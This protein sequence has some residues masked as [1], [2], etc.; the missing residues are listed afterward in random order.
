MSKRVKSFVRIRPYIHSQDGKN[1]LFEFDINDRKS[2]INIESTEFAFDQIFREDQNNIMIYSKALQP[3][4]QDALRGINTTV[5]AY[6]QTCSGKTHTIFG[7]KESEKGIIYSALEDIFSLNNQGDIKVK[8]LVSFY[9]IY[10]EQIND[11]LG[12]RDDIPIKEINGSFILANLAEHMVQSSEEAIDLLKFGNSNKAMGCSYLHEKSSRSHCVFRLHLAIKD[13]GLCEINFVDLAGSEILTDSYGSQQQKETKNINMSLF[14]L[15]NVIFSLSENAAFIP[16]RNS[17][18]TKLLQNS[19]G[20]NSQTAIFCMVSPLECHIQH[21]KRTLSFGQTAS[22]IINNLLIEKPIYKKE[23]DVIKEHV[24]INEQKISFNTPLKDQINQDLQNEYKIFD[25]QIQLYTYGDPKSAN[26]AIVLPAYGSCGRKCM[27]YSYDALVEKNF[28]I[29]SLDY[30]G[31]NSS[32][33]QKLN[34]RGHEQSV[35]FLDKIIK[36][37]FDK[38][39]N[40]ILMGYDYGAALA[41]NYG[42]VNN[43]KVKQIFSFHPAW[44][45]DLAFLKDLKQK[46]V[47]L[48]VTAEQLHPLQQGEKMNK[49]I[50]K[51]KLIKLNCGKFNAEKPKKAYKCIGDQVTQQIIDNLDP[52]FQKSQEQ[53]NK[54]IREQIDDEQ[55]QTDQINQIEQGD[56]KQEEKKEEEI[57]YDLDELLNNKEQY[58]YYKK[59][60]RGACL[61]KE[62]NKQKQEPKQYLFLQEPNP[63]S[64]QKDLQK[65]AI[66]RFKELLL[67]GDLQEYYKGYLNSTPLRTQAIKLFG[68][69]PTLIPY[70][71]DLDKFKLIW[72]EQNLPKNMEKISDFPAFLRGRQVHVKTKVGT[73]VFEKDYLE[74]KE[75]GEECI[76]HKS[77]IQNYN[78]DEG[79]FQVKVLPDKIIKVEEQEIYRLNCPTNFHGNPLQEGLVFEDG[80]KCKYQDLITKAKLM[81]AALSISDLVGQLDYSLNFEQ[82]PNN[83]YQVNDQNIQIQQKCVE[84]ISKCID[85]IHLVQEGIHPS[86]YIAFECGKLAYFGQG[87]NNF[88]FTIKTTFFIFS[89]K[90]PYIGFCGLCFFTSIQS[91][92]RDRSQ[93][94][95]RC[96]TKVWQRDQ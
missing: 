69:L 8:A 67:S 17:A 22:K 60:I 3:Y 12:E 4:I 63:N 89:R 1:K 94:Q 82:S 51:C 9:E 19:L 86:R 87:N 2:L 80:I 66:G 53:L 78:Q 47:L 46:V 93:I 36:Q 62:I 31:Q 48:W 39:N 35:P 45:Q 84:R 55:K 20:G 10:N 54:Q 28:Y 7:H 83:E 61:R 73:Q 11:L 79:T 38:Y 96:F 81:E 91:Y 13:K 37:E 21:S 49:I 65:W 57:E 71:S 52:I 27:A 95:G 30:P 16:Y 58:L 64:S 76:T 24:K 68:N 92:F 59:N 42:L 33:G 70:E 56:V 23:S 14:N 6:G 5:F 44:S 34:V 25:N 77:Y 90:L 88:K 29:I 41:M 75:D 85:L 26:L 43:P 32:G 18:L 15:K 72:G 74:Y 50:P 40:I